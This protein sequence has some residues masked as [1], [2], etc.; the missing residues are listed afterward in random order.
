[1]G[2]AGGSYQTPKIIRW[3]LILVRAPGA[4][5]GF[6]GGSP[7]NNS[8]IKVMSVSTLKKGYRTRLF[9]TPQNGAGRNKS[10][11]NTKKQQKSTKRSFCQQLPVGG[12]AAKAQ[13]KQH[14]QKRRSSPI[15]LHPFCGFLSLR[16]FGSFVASW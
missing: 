16:F 12:F 13:E 9:V 11:R 14:L 3:K 2:R 4:S 5:T 1:M 15:L 10:G 7:E 6:S 8:K